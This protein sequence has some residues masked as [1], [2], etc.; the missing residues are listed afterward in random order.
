M[1]TSAL[2]SSLE[3][4]PSGRAHPVWF[5]SLAYCR[6]KLLDGG[7]VPW[8]SPGELSAFFAKSQGMF[9][10]DAL[11]IDLDDLYSQRVAGDDALSAA[12]TARTRPGFAL[13][14]LLADERTRG[15]AEGAMTALGAAHTGTPVLISIPSPARWLTIASQQ[16]GVAVTEPP[17]PA[18]VENA[19]IYMADLLRI[20]A[21][22]RVDGLVLNEGPVTEEDLADTDSYRPVLNVAA[23]YEWPVW[24]RTDEAGCWPRG[25]IEGV[26]GWLGSRPPAGNGSRWGIVLPPGPGLETGPLP[27]AGGGPV[28]AIVP[29]AADPELVM[30]WVRQLT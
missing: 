1:V 29:G 12:M 21:G 9:H 27:G 23:H 18:P 26:L 2:D 3:Q 13:R 15:I 5:D 10:S 24:I 8:E 6:A 22:A 28:L 17:D 25:E 4:P 16:A 14:T 20:F 19:A 7:S 30:R 11:L